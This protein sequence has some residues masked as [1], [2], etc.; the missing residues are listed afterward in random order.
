M[1]A[2]ICCPGHS[3]CRSGVLVQSFTYVRYLKINFVNLE[4]NQTIHNFAVGLVNMVKIVY[5]KMVFSKVVVIVKE[6]I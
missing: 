4:I 3:V 5:I 1:P 2:H 6:Y